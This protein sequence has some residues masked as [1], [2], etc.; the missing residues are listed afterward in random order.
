MSKCPNCDA[1]LHG[2]S[3][4]QQCLCGAQLLVCPDAEFDGGVW[5][6]LT[7]VSLVPCSIVSSDVGDEDKRVR[8]FDVVANGRTLTPNGF[9]TESEARNWARAQGYAIA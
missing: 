2:L 4:Y 7:D 8:V 9:N 5:R 6:D 1:D 3:G